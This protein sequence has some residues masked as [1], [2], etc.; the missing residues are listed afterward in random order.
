MDYFAG[1]DVSMGGAHTCLTD[2]EGV[3]A[4]ETEIQATRDA[5]TAALATAP[6]GRWLTVSGC[7]LQA[8]AWPT[9]GR[10]ADSSDAAAEILRLPTIFSVRG[11]H[12]VVVRVAVLDGRLGAQEE[13][14]CARVPNRATNTEFR[15]RH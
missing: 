15:I 8:G 3:V 1:F 5:I 4:H 10:A 7:V 14:T 11:A 12:R 9:P 6:P 13:K 2:H